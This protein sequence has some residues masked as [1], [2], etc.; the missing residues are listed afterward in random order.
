[1]PVLEKQK[2]ELFAIGVAKGLSPTIAY[3]QV[4]PEAK[5]APGSALRLTRNA[6]IAKRIAELQDLA[7]NG[8]PDISQMDIAIMERDGQVRFKYERWKELTARKAD[9]ELIKSERAQIMTDP[10]NPIVGKASINSRLPGL[11][12]GLMLLDFKLVGKTTVPTLELDTALLGE[13]RAINREK[14]ALESE[15]AQL[16]G[17]LKPVNIS[18]DARQDNRQVNQTNVQ[19]VKMVSSPADEKGQW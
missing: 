4:Y 2:Y 7:R 10:A 3:L 15:I 19:I 12:T 8:L 13:L 17:F 1:M 14:S 9:L 11:S 6:N 18:I 16:M 5:G